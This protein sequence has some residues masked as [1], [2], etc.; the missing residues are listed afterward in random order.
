MV[1]KMHIGWQPDAVRQAVSNQTATDLVCR[2][3]H[4][5]ACCIDYRFTFHGS[6]IDVRYSGKARQQSGAGPAIQPLRISALA[7][8]QGSRE[9]HQKK[10]AVLLHSLP[11]LPAALLIGSNKRADDDSAVLD[12]LCGDQTGPPQVRF[13]IRSGKAKIGR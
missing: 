9:M 11:N 8:F 1:R 6:F 5:H 13:A 12:N 10:S 7:L 2:L 3:T 4:S